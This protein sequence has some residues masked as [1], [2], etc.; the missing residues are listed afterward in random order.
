VHHMIASS[1]P[2]VHH[3]RCA[4]LTITSYYATHCASVVITSCCASVAIAPY[5]AS[6]PLCISHH[7][8]LLCIT[9]TVHLSPSHLLCIS[10]HHIL[11]C[12]TSTVHLSP[13][14]PLCITLPTTTRI[15]R[16]NCCCKNLTPPVSPC[17]P[18][19]SLPLSIVMIGVGDGPW[20]VRWFEFNCGVCA[21]VRLCMCVYVC[22]FVCV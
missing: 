17:R 22:V 20:E 7:H 18:F 4:S 5:C 6:H 1:Q 2:T 19:S 14:H 21:R 8:T 12:I 3:I 13:S 15:C 10:R 16:S 11:L 9:S